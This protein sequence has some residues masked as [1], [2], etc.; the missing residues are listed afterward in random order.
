MVLPGS[1]SGSLKAVTVLYTPACTRR[2][3]PPWT[4]AVVATAEVVLSVA[5]PPMAMV[6]SGRV[7]D[8]EYEPAQT[9][10]ANS[11]RAA[12]SVRDSAPNFKGEFGCI[13]TACLPPA[14]DARSQ[15][16]THQ[17]GSCPPGKR[18]FT[19]SA[20]GK[21]SIRCQENASEDQ[22]GQRDSTRG[23]GEPFRRFFGAWPHS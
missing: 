8:C 3:A 14:R 9:V 1:R 13:L 17:N 11:R 23:P 22:P 20:S 19:S 15:S 6:P 5:P 18:I 4:E 7:K 12:A 21:R 10:P 16:N 2:S